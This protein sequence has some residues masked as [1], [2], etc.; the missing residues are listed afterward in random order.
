MPTPTT[1]PPLSARAIPDFV[2]ALPATLGGLLTLSAFTPWL[3]RA[4]PL[5]LAGTVSAMAG[6]LAVALQ[7]RLWLRDCR[8]MSP[9][10]TWPAAALCAIAIAAAPGSDQLVSIGVGIGASALWVII[11]SMT[12]HT[13]TLATNDPHN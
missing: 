12:L 8:W 9:G 13:I 5:W 6:A 1:T 11:V 3:E 10:R 7:R 2:Y 4:V